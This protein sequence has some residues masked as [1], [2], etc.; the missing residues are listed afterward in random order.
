MKNTKIMKNSKN[1]DNT[2][3]TTKQ[4][5]PTTL[6]FRSTRPALGMMMLYMLT[7]TTM[8]SACGPQQPLV[9]AGTVEAYASDIVTEASG[10]VTELVLSEGATV[11]AGDVIAQLDGAIQ[12]T[13]VSQLEQAVV[14]KAAMLKELQNGNRT[15][16]RDQARF[17]VDAARARYDE[18]RQ[19]PSLEAVRAAEAQVA[20]ARTAVDGA[21]V[22]LAHT[23]QMEQD[24]ETL[25]RDG[26][27]AD[28]AYE[29]AVFAHEVSAAALKT[30][31]KQLEASIAQLNQVKHGAGEEAIAVAKAQMDQSD[32][33]LAQ[34][35]NGATN[36]SLTIAEADLAQSQAA[37]AQ[38]RLMLERYTLRAPCEGT[39]TLL[40]VN[41]GEVVNAGAAI[42]TISQ[43]SDLSVRLYIPQRNLAAI[44]LGDSLNLTA[45]SF[46]DKLFPGAIT[47]ISDKAEFTPRNTETTASKESTV[48]RFEVAVS[49]PDS[50]LKPGMALEVGI[51]GAYSE[52]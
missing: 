3:D 29:D 6:L 1:T 23:K 14:A 51:P 22:Q 44:H 32:A 24:A 16:Q 15:E 47:F 25:H 18:V 4:I 13:V 27:L 19:G 34:V 11:A 5:H 10:R 31:Q 28:A 9:L 20:I 21:V 35:E 52:Q 43:L 38:G 49:Q 7:F 26:A 41:Q 50:G 37:L 39:I 2:T 42:G 17:A 40:S 33:Q 30:A 12:A 45:T 46:P 48:F 8:L 36:A